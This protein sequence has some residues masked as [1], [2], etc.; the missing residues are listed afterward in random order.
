MLSSFIPNHFPFRRYNGLTGVVLMWILLQTI[1]SFWPTKRKG[2]QTQMPKFK[3]SFTLTFI[4]GLSNNKNKHIEWIGFSPTQ[5]SQSRWERICRFLS[6]EICQLSFYWHATHQLG[7]TLFTT[8]ASDVP[9][10]HNLLKHRKSACSN[11]NKTI[12]CIL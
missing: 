10:A 8:T 11:N 3:S 9:A 5:S 4:F 7:C 6:I 1:D 12:L 2:S